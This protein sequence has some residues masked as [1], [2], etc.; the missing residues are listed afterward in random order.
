MKRPKLPNSLA[1]IRL[2]TSADI[3][4]DQLPTGEKTATMR[5]HTMQDVKRGVPD[6]TTPWITF[7]LEMFDG[8]ATQMAT[9]AAA[10]RRWNPDDATSLPD[11]GNAEGITSMK[12]EGH[13]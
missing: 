2:Y 3:Y 9:I 12:V 11:V 1:G 13:E 8:L 7:S 4:L 5:F 6:G 10:G